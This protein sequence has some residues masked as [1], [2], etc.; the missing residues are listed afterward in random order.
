MLCLDRLE[1]ARV[2]NATVP[3]I[4]PNDPPIAVPI[5][6]VAII[7]AIAVKRA[8]AAEAPPIDDASAV[9]AGN[10]APASIFITR[11]PPETWNVDVDVHVLRS[12]RHG[13]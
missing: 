6:P 7:R 1:R 5:S 10:I 13:E 4:E 2:Q 8:N 9:A 3:G 12:S 11:Q